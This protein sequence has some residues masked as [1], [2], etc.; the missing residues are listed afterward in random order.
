MHH[1]TI[2]LVVGTLLLAIS[3]GIPAGAADKPIRAHYFGNSLTDQL[4]YDYF[5]KLATDAGHPLEWKREMAPGVPVVWHWDQ[6]P[7]WEKKLTDEKWDVVTL[8]PFAY[9]EVEY[10]PSEEF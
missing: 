1:R 8:Q 10:P 9:F 3:A 4:K 6:K 5:K 2:T 7:R